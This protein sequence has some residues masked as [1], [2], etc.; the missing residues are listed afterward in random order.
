M[1][2]Y[3]SLVILSFLVFGCKSIPECNEAKTNNN[4]GKLF[5]T[6]NDEYA[7]FY[8]DNFLYFTS[9]NLKNPES[10]RILYSE[11]NNNEVSDIYLDNNLPINFF[12]NSGLPSFFEQNGKKYLIFAGMNNLVKRA[13]SDLFISEYKDNKWSIPIPI[14]ELNTENY[15]SYPSVSKDGKFIVFVSDRKDGIGGLDLYLSSFDGEKWLTP[16]NLGEKINTNFDEISPS[17]LPNYDLLFSSNKSN[18][19]GGFDIYYSKYESDGWQIPENVDQPINSNKDEIGATLI[20]DKIVISSNRE[21]GCGGKDLYMFDFCKDIIYKGI[22]KATNNSISLEG[23]AYLLD[24]KKNVLEVKNVES[25]GLFDFKL[26]PNTKYYIRYINYCIPTYVP[27]QEVSTFCDNKKNIRFNSNFIIDDAAKFF[28]FT[29]YK[30]PFFVTGYYQPNTLDNL[31]ALKLKFNYNLLGK[32]EKTRYIENPQ[33]KYDDYTEQVEAALNEVSSYIIEMLNNLKNDCIISRPKLKIKVLG[34]AD[35]RPISSNQIFDDDDIDDNELNF[36]FLRGQNIDNLELSKLRAYFTALYLKRKINEHNI[37][38]KQ[39]SNIIW[40]I[41]GKGVADDSLDF[42]L[43]RRV[44][45]EIGM[46]K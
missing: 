37:L 22:V 2:V 42:L 9:L 30:I 16:V 33:N 40:E 18:G 39:E 41:E 45:V 21:G 34:Y 43:Q 7:P 13:N 6:S 32:N 14:L 11:F 38:N 46:I 17:L 25:D 12:P 24:S 26:Q 19:V 28:D 36:K 4:L 5:N 10:I 3:I 44:N 31:N 35:P 15:E 8:Y 29:N 20:N 27:D 1:K 23:K